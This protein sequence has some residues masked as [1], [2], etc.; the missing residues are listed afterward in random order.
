M[1]SQEQLPEG[2]N[3]GEGEDQTLEAQDTRLLSASQI[4]QIWNSDDPLQ[5]LFD[6]FTSYFNPTHDHE[7]DNVDDDKINFLAEFQIYNLIF[8][9]NDLKLEDYQIAHILDILW[10]LLAV[11]QDGSI[12]DES[13]WAQGN[14]DQALNSK[15]DEIKV[16]LIDKLKAG[17]LTKEQVLA[18]MGYMKTG[19]FKHFRLIDFWLRNRQQSTIKSITLFHDEPLT[20]GNLDGAQEIV[21]E[22][23]IQ[24]HQEGEADQDAEMQPEMENQEAVEGE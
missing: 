5:E 24:H 21:E 17:I 11:N 14:Y 7:Y 20:T 8:L 23:P 2:E 4:D 15:M 9:K 10:N 16:G 13:I 18:I 3:A 19:Y 6:I 1:A 12:S 22:E